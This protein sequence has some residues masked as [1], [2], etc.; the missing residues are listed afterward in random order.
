MHRAASVPVALAVLLQLAA[1]VLLEPLA[2]EPVLLL[3]LLV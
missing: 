3:F 1:P 2:G